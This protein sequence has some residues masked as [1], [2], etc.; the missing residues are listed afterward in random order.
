MAKLIAP[1]AFEQVSGSSTNGEFSVQW[2]RPTDTTTWQV[3][4]VIQETNTIYTDIHNDIGTGVVVYKAKGL[5]NGHNYNVRVRAIPDS[6]SVADA[7]NSDW[8]IYISGIE[9]REIWVDPTTLILSAGDSVGDANLNTALDNFDYL[10]TELN[11]AFR[12]Q[13]DDIVGTFLPYPEPA[14]CFNYHSYISNAEEDINVLI[15]LDNWGSDSRSFVLLKKYTDNLYYMVYNISAT[16]SI[17][18]GTNLCVA[19]TS[20]RPLVQKSFFLPASENAIDGAVF[21][22]FLHGFSIETNGAITSRKEI[23]GSG[24]ANP[25]AI[26][27]GGFIPMWIDASV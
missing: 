4:Y 13:V 3:E 6:T 7:E 22:D 8:T 2:Q 11:R 1:S 24:V 26:V 17:P 12:E 27:G 16:V 20:D 19:P 23:R 21:R 25:T 15:A 9:V 18:A 5:Y 14:S 10:N